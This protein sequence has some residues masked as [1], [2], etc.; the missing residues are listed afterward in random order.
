M[1]KV[2]KHCS[3]LNYIRNVDKD[4]YELIQDLCIGR[5]FL[6]K[7][8]SL[9]LTFLRPDEKLS[10]KL[11]KEANGDNPEEV[12]SKI[13]A[14]VLPVCLSN[15]SDFSENKNNIPNLYKKKLPIVSVTNTEV[16]LDN[17]SKITVDKDF[18]KRKDV[19]NIAVYIVN[20]EVPEGT[21][22]AEELNLKTGKGYTGGA[23]YYQNNRAQLFD[24]ILKLH[25]DN[26]Y[27]GNAALEVLT[28]LCDY[29]QDNNHPSYNT[30]CTQ[31]SNDTLASLTIILQ[32][33][34]NNCDYVDNSTFQ[35]WAN[36]ST[37]TDSEYSTIYY[38]KPKVIENYQKHRE[39]GRNAIEVKSNII[40]KCRNNIISDTSKI[41][42]VNELNN[43][44]DNIKTNGLFNNLGVRS[45]ENKKL[46]LAEAELR[47]F[48]AL[49]HDNSPNHKLNLDEATKLY[50]KDCTLNE[51]Y[52]LS[53]I[54]QIKLSN[55]AFYYSSVYLILR[56]NALG[57]IPDFY[58]ECNSSL[59]NIA[60]E[61]SL[62]NLD[63]DF[64]LND[65]SSFY[66]ERDNLFSRISSSYR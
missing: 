65:Y 10:K 5:W 9:G 22:D 31:L 41:T 58:E 38:Y 46:F 66:E 20:N 25:C 6:P 48:S 49:L 62:I 32:P 11:I 2:K 17:D 37:K 1:S 40:E 35:S 3:I 64:N 50:T 29:L 8:N 14:M 52:I 45:Q 34:K 7:K 63:L 19:E 61:D 30:V 16:I 24:S 60:D 13:K 55:I 26:N 56:S 44:I 21:E 42:I 57:Y 28:S 12:V 33:Y 15:L 36:E 47:V 4:F 54:T 39:A 59:N 27:N 18:V 51:P 53:D 23:D 43:Y